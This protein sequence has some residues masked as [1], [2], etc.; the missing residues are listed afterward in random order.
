MARASAYS[1]L[2]TN[3]NFLLTEYEDMCTAS[4]DYD[5]ITGISGTVTLEL[6]Y[7]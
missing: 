4:G 7:T 1:T 2:T 6:T 3:L 5:Q